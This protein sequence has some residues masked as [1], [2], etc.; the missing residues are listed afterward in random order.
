MY[1]ATKVGAGLALTLALSLSFANRA[2]A[3]ASDYVYTPIVVEGEKEI[4][5]KFGSSKLRDGTR[6]SVVSLGLGYG[7][8]A[9]W[10]TELYAKGNRQT[11]TGWRFDAVEW[12]NKFQLTETGKYPVDVG[13]LVEI[14]RPQ[15]RSEG[16]ELRFG[17][18]FQA[19]LT[20][21]L[22]ANANLLFGRHY[23][24]AEPSAMSLDYQW[25]LKYRWKPAFEVGA[26]GLGSMGP[27]RDWLPGH[28]QEHQAGPAVFGKVRLD[29]HHAINYNAALLF[30]GNT[31]SPRNTL[32]LQVEYEY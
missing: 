14:E 28:E 2:H 1:H 26:Q 25:Q 23:R 27:W 32:R 6:E 24:S 15:D 16:W 20:P 17:P 22:V 10:F 8:N 5:F 29:G 30:G 13:L 3:G 4:D 12:E 21:N 7:V 31:N 9:W 19:E 18:L 11:P